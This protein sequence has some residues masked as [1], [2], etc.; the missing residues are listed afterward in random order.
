MIS[1]FLLVSSGLEWSSEE[2]PMNWIVVKVDG[3]KRLDFESSS[4]D[5]GFRTSSCSFFSTL[6]SVISVK[7]H[8]VNT[9]TRSKIHKP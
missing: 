6:A 2:Y 7:F 5:L 8:T 1:A 4:K 3:W 9:T